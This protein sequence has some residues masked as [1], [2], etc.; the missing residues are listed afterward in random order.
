M[1]NALVVVGVLVILQVVKFIQNKIQPF[2]DR[3]KD[4]V[5]SLAGIVL[6][7][8]ASFLGLVEVDTWMELLPLLVAPQGLFVV[9]KKIFGK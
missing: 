5:Y 7:G 4:V 9:I 6:V 3:T 1:E 8:L 2:S